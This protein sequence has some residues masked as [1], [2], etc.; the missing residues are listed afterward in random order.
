PCPEPLAYQDDPALLGAPFYVMQML[1]GIILRRDPPPGLV[2]GPARAATL[3][4]AL[5][6]QQIAL[7]QLDYQALGLG[8]LGQ[9]QG[10]VARRVAGW[11]QRYHRARTDDVP[12]CASL[13]ALLDPAQ[14]ADCTRPG[15]IHN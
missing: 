1:E 6:D 3:C 11:S 13:M 14:P 8:D 5:W 10:Y 7:H 2:Y 9:P 15:L 12:D 4:R